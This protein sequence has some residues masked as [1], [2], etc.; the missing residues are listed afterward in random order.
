MPWVLYSAKQSP[1]NGVALVVNG[2][3][4]ISTFS[5]KPL[6]LSAIT[7]TAVRHVKVKGV[8]LEIYLYSN[9]AGTD[10][11]LYSILLGLTCG[12]LRRASVLLYPYH[13]LPSGQRDPLRPLS[14][15]NS[16]W[17]TNRWWMQ[18]TNRLPVLKP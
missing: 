12:L 4:A 14:I 17:S 1:Y 15:A 13:A 7:D 11:S 16:T 18:N 8:P 2:K 9:V 10:N 3:T 6:P 5:N